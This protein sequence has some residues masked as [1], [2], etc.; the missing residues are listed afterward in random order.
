MPEPYRFLFLIPYMALNEYH[1]LSSLLSVFREISAAICIIN[2]LPITV[3]SQR[4]HILKTLKCQGLS[5]ELLHC[6]FR[7]IIIPAKAFARD[8][9]ITGVGLSVCLFVTTITK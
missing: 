9:V 8:Y 4:L 1:Q 2:T 3:S 5:L 6:V 7:A